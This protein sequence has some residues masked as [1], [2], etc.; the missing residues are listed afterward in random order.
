MKKLRDMHIFYHEAL[1]LYVCDA[2]FFFSQNIWDPIDKSACMAWEIEIWEAN[3]LPRLHTSKK[4]QV[5]T[6]GLDHVKIITLVL[7]YWVDK[8]P[9]V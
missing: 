8:C 9:K 7:Y 1:S 4:S 3:F 6:W 5:G 2:F